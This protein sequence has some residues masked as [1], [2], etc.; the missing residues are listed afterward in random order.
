MFKNIGLKCVNMSPVLCIYNLPMTSKRIHFFHIVKII[1]INVRYWY[2]SSSP[3]ICFICVVNDIEYQIL[4]ISSQIYYL[5]IAKILVSLPKDKNELFYHKYKCSTKDFEQH[6]HFWYLYQIWASADTVGLN[7]G[8]R[9]NLHLF[10]V[11]GSSDGSAES[12]H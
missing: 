7:Y 8:L 9:F 4:N 2:S 12:T 3:V 1:I 10:F 11:Y 6:L 5:T